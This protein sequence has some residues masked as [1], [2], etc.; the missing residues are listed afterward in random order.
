MIRRTLS[1]TLLFILVLV[2]FSRCSIAAQ[3]LSPSLQAAISSNQ[4][5][6]D[7][8]S[9]YVSHDYKKAITNLKTALEELQSQAGF[10]TSLPWRVLVDNLGMAQGVSGDLKSSKTTF[11]YG[12]S[13][14]PN[15]PMFHYNL[16][17]VFAE[18]RD[19]DAAIAELRQAFALKANANPG[20]PMPN[21]ATDDS[22]ARFMKDKTF[23][24]ALSEIRTAGR[25]YPDR[26]DFTVSAS[27]WILTVPAGDFE[28]VKSQSSPDG[29]KARF[30]FSS[31][32]TGVA[33]SIMIEPAAACTD[34]K[35]CRDFVRTS[36]SQRIADAKNVASGEVGA[37]SVFEYFV[38]EFRGLPVRQQ[39]M[40]AEFVRDGF[41]VD[42]HLSKV[43]YDKKDRKLFEALI[44][45]VV[46]EQKK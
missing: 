2:G 23:V 30:M 12:V 35:S 8:L 5:L 27:P 41:W 16:A 45:S 17:C 33:A 9:A 46:F 10:E 26:L 18:V 3:S 14:D 7:G 11:D 22:F 20:E 4:H 24:A 37:V 6:K 36:N 38:P 29:N 40:F 39:N 43:E 25:L 42:I 13:K 15:Y 34:S 44:N 19:R 28:V 21:P 32:K 1:S 31:E